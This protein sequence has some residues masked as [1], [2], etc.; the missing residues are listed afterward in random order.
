MDELSTA[1]LERG[2]VAD[3]PADG[4]VDFLSLPVLD[5]DHRPETV[6]DCE[7]E[8][9]GREDDESGGA[10]SGGNDEEGEVGLEE[11]EVECDLWVEVVSWVKVNSSVVKT[12]LLA[13]AVTKLAQFLRADGPFC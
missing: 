9:V 1:V 3:A 2:D 12:H 8:G 5:E 6:S 13:E 4:E 10:D 7:G 11:G